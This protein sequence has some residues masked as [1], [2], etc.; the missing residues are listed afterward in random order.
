MGAELCPLVLLV[1]SREQED[2][3]TVS[4]KHLIL[5]SVSPLLANS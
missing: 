3:G 1:G 5:Q 4:N 2:H